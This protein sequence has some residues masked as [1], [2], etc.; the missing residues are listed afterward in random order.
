MEY[1]QF[2]RTSL[3]VST[4]CYGT[5]QF[6]GDWG[7][8]DQLQWD[9]GKAT[10]HKALELGINFFDSA[11]AYGFGLAERMLGEALRPYLRSQRDT[12]VIATIRYRFFKM[13]FAKSILQVV[14]GGALVFLAGVLI[15][16]G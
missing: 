8:V 9:A 16:G 11:Q 14:I 1:T 15:G 7:R 13:P 12:I 3:R 5:W 6:G 2:G 10:V 4:I